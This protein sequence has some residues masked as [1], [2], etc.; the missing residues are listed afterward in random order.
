MTIRSQ[1]WRAGIGLEEPRGAVWKVLLQG[2]VCGHPEIAGPDHLG[3]VDIG[4]IVD[5]LLLEDMARPVTHEHQLPAGVMRKLIVHLDPAG[6]IALVDV[7]SGY[8]L[9]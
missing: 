2:L 6:G 4:C 3:G 5:P 8:V 1:S 7:I 9:A